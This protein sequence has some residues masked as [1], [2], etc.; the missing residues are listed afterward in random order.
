MFSLNYISCF[1]L[2]TTKTILNIYTTKSRLH[3]SPHSCAVAL[4]KMSKLKLY[5]TRPDVPEKAIALLKEKFEVAMWTGSGPVPR[6]DLLRGVRGCDALYCFLTDRID[7][8]VLDCAGE[9]LRVV[10]TMSVGHD[11][12]DVP[13]LKQRGVLLGITPDVLTD[14]VADLTLAL[15]LATS[16]RLFE[17]NRQ[18]TEGK[19]TAWAPFWM[20][21][22]GLKASTA[23]IVGFGR[24]GQEVARRLRPFKV[25]ALLYSGRSDKP[26][27]GELGATRV[28][29][30]DLLE[31]SDFV[32]VTCALTPD[33]REMF[34]DAL[35]SKMKRSAVFINV[36]RGGVVDQAA[37]L[38]ALQGGVILA[39]G[40][41]VTTP[42]PLPPSH[43]LCSLPNCVLLPHIGSATHQARTDMAV[44]TARNILAAVEGRPL[45]APAF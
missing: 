23:G 44:L 2:K 18:I 9:S 16:R 36:S 38:R 37:L 33:T 20:C 27:A 43:P 30:G 5:I 15:L 32:I 41:D 31:R 13:V 10:G 8:E 6:E 24:I 21:G 3:L 25:A 22:P 14:A 4:Y 42:E 28:P 39:A 29:L 11:H 26:E 45:P 34:N 40:L 35:F 19:W 7:Q 12:V 1:V 17:A